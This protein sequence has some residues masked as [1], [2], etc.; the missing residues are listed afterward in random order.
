MRIIRN[1][2]LDYGC[3]RRIRAVRWLPAWL[4]V[5][6][7]G[8][9]PLQTV[10]V[11]AGAGSRN[12]TPRLR[13]LHLLVRETEFCGLRPAGDFRRRTRENGRNSVRRPRCGHR[14]RRC[15][16]RARRYVRRSPLRRPPPTLPRQC[17]RQ[18]ALERQAR[19]MAADGL[20][21]SRSNLPHHCRSAASSAFVGAGSDHAAS[22]VCVSRRSGARA[23]PIDPRIAPR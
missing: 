8:L 13:P 7:A 9:G 14:R 19:A 22:L 23:E 4:G 18:C 17:A 15:A 16:P 20:A 10:L 3:Y 21:P 1:A 5:W 6:R 12:D 2:A 11:E